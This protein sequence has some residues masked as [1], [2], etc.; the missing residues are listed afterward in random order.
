VTIA[1]LHLLTSAYM[2]GVI[3]FVQ[4][5]HYPMLHHADG[6]ERAAG[7]REYTRR[8]GWVVAPVMLAELAL[9]IWDLTTHP[10]PRGVV[11]GILLAVIWLSTFLLQVPL[12]EKLT[13][14]FD[15]LLQRRLVHS[16]WIRTIGWT[17]RSLLLA[18]VR[19]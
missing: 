18:Y 13:Q 11:T 17:L 15:P 1:I 4:L 10:G 5:V 3:W 16:N 7:H 6:P 9:Q 14:D 2:T 12:H 19:N 8:M